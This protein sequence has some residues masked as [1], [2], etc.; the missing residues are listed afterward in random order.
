MNETNFEIGM[1]LE[2]VDLH[3]PSLIRA[4]TIVETDTNRIRINYDGWPKAY[5]VWLNKNSEDIYP[6]NWCNK[7]GHYICKPLVEN[8]TNNRMNGTGCTTTGCNGLGHVKG[9]KYTTHYT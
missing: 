7:T 5:D 9:S 6:I 4:A 3:N 8:T 1:K 2:A